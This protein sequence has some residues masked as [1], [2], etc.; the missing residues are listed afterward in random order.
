MTRSEL[1]L[2]L[3]ALA[4]VWSGTRPYY[5]IWLDAR[6]YAAQALARLHPASFSTDLY[7]IHGSQDQFTAFSYLYAPVI[8]IFGLEAAH[9]IA[10]GIGQACWLIAAWALASALIADCRARLWAFV[11]LLL[12]APRVGVLGTISYGEPFATP[13]LFAEAA[14]L[15]A[16][17]A[18]LNGRRFV[19]AVALGGGIAMHPLIAL[20]ALWTLILMCLLQRSLLAF[21]FAFGGALLATALLLLPLEQLDFA[22]MDAFWLDVT[23]RRSYWVFLTMWPWEAWLRSGTTLLLGAVVAATLSGTQFRF[24]LAASATGL[25]GVFLT[26]AG[27]DVGHLHLVSAAQPARALWIL[28]LAVNL[29]LVPALFRLA[30]EGALNWIYARLLVALLPVTLAAMK[31][32]PAMSLAAFPISVLTGLLVAAFRLGIRFEGSI[33]RIILVSVFGTSVAWF[34]VCLLMSASVVFDSSPDTSGLVSA[35]RA[36]MLSGGGTL[37]LWTV[38]TGRLR[39]RS[40]SV[41]WLCGIALATAAVMTFDQRSDWQKF[42][43]TQVPVEDPLRDFVPRNSNIYWEGGLEVVWLRL[44]QASYFSCAQG[45]GA[46]FFRATAVSFAERLPSFRFQRSEIDCFGLMQISENPPSEADLVRAC[47]R[48]PA[49]DYVVLPTRVE[50]LTPSATFHVPSGRPVPN[51]PWR[52]RPAGDVFRYN[53]DDL[54]RS[55]EPAA[56]G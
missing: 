25:T 11:G 44:R 53:C 40:M 1:G 20:P 8:E 34:T 38:L 42:T 6:F 56:A 9:A 10:F 43:E 48:E 7:F 41:G 24:A 35:A 3:I 22:R 26:Y 17:A 15:F 55:D 32:L 5:G 18:V 37:L 2:G 21:A 47:T 27:T 33:S 29:L 30:S 19:G 39:Q 14:S 46:G 52:S 23:Q 4:L 49:L 51:A 13:R 45:T 31:G 50:H 28:V 16:I 12:F 54:R 36:C